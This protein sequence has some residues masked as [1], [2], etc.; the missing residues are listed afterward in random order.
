[1]HI[2]ELIVDFLVLWPWTFLVLRKHYPNAAI[3]AAEI[4]PDVVD[5]AKKFFG[6]RED[7]LA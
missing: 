5:V 2:L 3:D 6:F 7:V 4:D 1:M